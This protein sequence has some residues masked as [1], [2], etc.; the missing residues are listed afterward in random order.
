V[1]QNITNVIPKRGGC[2]KGATIVASR[3]REQTELLLDE[4][5]AE[6]SKKVEA[7]KG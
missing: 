4:I 1:L 7:G 2:P 5:T 3:G 6:W